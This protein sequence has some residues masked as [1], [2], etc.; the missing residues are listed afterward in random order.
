MTRAANLRE[1]FY[2]NDHPFP[3]SDQ[4]SFDLQSLAYMSDSFAPLKLS[5]F[6][7][8][9]ASKFEDTENGDSNAVRGSG[10]DR[11]L[12]DIKKPD[13]QDIIHSEDTSFEFPEKQSYEE[14]KISGKKKKLA[15]PEEVKDKQSVK[16]EQQE[17]HS[18]VKHNLWEDVSESE[19]YAEQQPTT[20]G[21]LNSSDPSKR[22]IRMSRQTKKTPKS[23]NNN[24]TTH[25]KNSQP[26][27]KNS[28]TASK[29]SRLVHS[30]SSTE[31][32]EQL[33]KDLHD[34][35]FEPK[36]PY[37]SKLPPIPGAIP[38]PVGKNSHSTLFAQNYGKY[39]ILPSIGK[40]GETEQTVTK[41]RLP[42]QKMTSQNVVTRADIEESHARVVKRMRVRH[43]LLHPATPGIIHQIL[44]D[45]N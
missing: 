11:K 43:Q 35:R 19:S 38:C 32:R 22:V 10:K 12:L 8:N 33:H 17:R 31:Q 26:S 3:S 18:L 9:N 41:Y 34:A 16:H 5:A 24:H 39:S 29:G 21:H 4:Q 23:A 44:K 7:Q 2:N 36:L 25:N 27:R 42:K 13:Q 28:H 40:D 20:K 30:T 45:D 37:E 14:R 1:K 15:Q 6:D